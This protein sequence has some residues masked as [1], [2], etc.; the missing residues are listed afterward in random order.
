MI[1][2]SAL[3]IDAT[4]AEA[5]IKTLLTNTGETGGTVIAEHTLWLALHRRVTLVGLVALTHSLTTP[6]LAMS[7]DATRVGVAGICWLWFRNY[8]RLSASCE[9][10]SDGPCGTAAN[11]VMVPHLTHSINPTCTGTGVNA[12]LGYAGQT[13]SAVIILQTLCSAACSGHRVSLVSS[14]AGA[15]HLTHIILA[16]LGV[17]ATWRGL[18]RVLEDTAS[19]PERVSGEAS[20]TPAVYILFIYNLNYLNSK[21]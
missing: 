10:V 1:D 20:Q 21:V 17:G 8:W 9:G 16:A 4:G 2:N 6:I 5:G 3:G 13:G 14:D 19:C 18:T 12:L 7:I 11:G 15:D